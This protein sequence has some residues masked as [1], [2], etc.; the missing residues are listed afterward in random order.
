MITA[1]ITCDIY[2]PAHKLHIY[3]DY[4]HKQLEKFIGKV[5]SDS[6]GCITEILEIID[7]TTYYNEKIY[8]KTTFAVECCNPKIGELLECEITHNDRIALGTS[9][10]LKIIIIDHPGLKEV[11]IGD[12]VLVKVMCKEVK[13][14]CSEVNIVG[15]FL[16]L[17]K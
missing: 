14:N 6:I 13:K 5:Y 7:I 17:K 8:F 11:K 9:S 2:V 10:M 4:I 15:E 3:H 1:E 16:G 12:K